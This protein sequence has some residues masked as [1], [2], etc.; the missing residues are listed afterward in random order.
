MRDHGCVFPV[1]GH[2][3]RRRIAVG[4]DRPPGWTVVHH[5]NE[6]W[7][8]GGTTNLDDGVLLCPH[9]HRILHTDGWAI[10]F[11]HDHIPDLV[12]PAHL[13]PHRRPRRHQRFREPT[14]T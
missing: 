10:R 7:A 14:H 11:T 5:A 6:H 8:N 4:E 1:W 3:H 9:H 12:P 13:D 2:P